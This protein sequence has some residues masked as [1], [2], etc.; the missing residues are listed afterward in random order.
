MIMKERRAGRQDWRKFKKTREPMML[1][2]RKMTLNTKGDDDDSHRNKK[3]SCLPGGFS[4]EILS[5]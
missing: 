1:K 4:Q 3:L 5:G 2:K